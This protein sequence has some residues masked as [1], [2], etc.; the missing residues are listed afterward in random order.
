MGGG[1]EEG[2]A[3][4]TPEIHLTE[5]VRAGI[6]TVVGTL[7]VDTTMK[8]MAG[9]LAKAKA[10]K[11]HEHVTNDSSARRRSYLPRPAGA[12]LGGPRHPMP[13]YKS[14]PEQF[15]GPAAEQVRLAE[16]LQRVG[17]TEDAAQ[18]LEAA[19][20]V[21]AADA[22]ELPGW[23]CGRLATLYRTLH[24]YDDE[25]RLLVRY[26][27]SQRS[28]DSRGRF[29]ARLSKARAMAE[30]ASRTDTHI[31]AT[32]KR[33]PSRRQASADRLQ[34]PDGA[35][36]FEADM[37]ADL[38]ASLVAAATTGELA[39]LSVAMHRLLRETRQRSLLPERMVAA[40]KVAWRGTSIPANVSAEAWI[41]L[42]R[43]ALPPTHAQYLDE[44]AKK[45]RSQKQTKSSRA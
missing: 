11:A 22:A 33:A 27:D 32:V 6:T 17:A 2:F 40:L 36:G 34:G 13:G 14:L 28:E 45:R 7:G 43:N 35:F 19:L 1:G 38:R 41:A 44:D 20:E 30:R 25:V 24:R 15:N 31:I 23:L 21:C 9:L 42:Y 26:R 5:I 12:Y 18:L 37:I 16:A 3:T 10:L 39:G 29:D 4:Q 8:T